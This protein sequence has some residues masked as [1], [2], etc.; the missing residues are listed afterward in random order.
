MGIKTKISLNLFLWALMPIILFSLVA[1]AVPYFIGTAD[2][3]TNYDKNTDWV[4][5]IL[6]NNIKFQTVDSVSMP[7]TYTRMNIYCSIKNLFPDTNCKD[8]ILYHTR[9]KDKYIL[10]LYTNS[11]MPIAMDSLYY[12]NGEWIGFNMQNGKEIRLGKMVGSPNLNET[13]VDISGTYINVYTILTLGIL[14]IC[15]VFLL[16]EWYIPNGFGVFLFWI[17][18]SFIG[19]CIGLLIDSFRGV[20][21]AS[22]YLPEIIALLFIVSEI[23][24][25][26]M[27]FNQLYAKSKHEMDDEK[28]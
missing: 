25:V 9:N 22:P 28:E 24:V 26:F 6:T 17:L 14:L 15:L 5:T 27:A 11:D 4:T 20:R 2:L 13:I 8:V 23:S 10:T 3:K 1:I 21:V 12:D 19:G 16:C 7:Y 18:L